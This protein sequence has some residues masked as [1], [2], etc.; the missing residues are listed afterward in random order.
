MTRQ[1]GHWEVTLR[2]ADGSQ[3]VM[4]PRHVVF[5]TGVSAIPEMPSQPGLDSFKGAVM[6][7]GSYTQ[8]AAWKGRNTLVLGTGNSAHDVAQDL[9]ASG[10]KVTMIQRSP[11]Y[12]VSI[13]EAQRV[14]S[15]YAEGMPTDDC[16]LLATAVPYPVLR[17]AYQLSTAVSRE[18]DKRLARGTGRA[19]VPPD[20][21]R[22]PYRLPDDVPAPRRRLLLQRRLFR[23]R[24][25]RAHGAGA[26]RHDRPFRARG[27]APERRAGAAGRTRW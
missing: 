19:R 8:G 24:R 18:A 11:T 12:I 20:R 6:H 16:D 13:Q 22:R 17:H 3:R 21:G 25:R 1:A 5:A 7:S 14:Y 2:L 10:A 27:R 15:L 4:R 9:Q 23:P 26:V